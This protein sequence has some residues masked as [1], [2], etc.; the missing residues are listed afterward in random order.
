MIMKPDK[1]AFYDIKST[2]ELI[3]INKYSLYLKIKA[4]KLKCKKAGNRWICSGKAIIDYLEG[5]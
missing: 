3:G 2:G 4:G 5:K 1:D